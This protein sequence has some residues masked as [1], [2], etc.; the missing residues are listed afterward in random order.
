MSIKCNGMKKV[1]RMIDEHG[2]KIEK[3]EDDTMTETITWHKT[4]NVLPE[5]SPAFLQCLIELLIDNGDISAAYYDPIKNI[6]M[7]YEY[8]EIEAPVYWAYAPSGPTQL[9]WEAE[10]KTKQEERHG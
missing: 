3:L 6:F 10:Q 8:E 2:N 9:K 4:S 1:K 7:D 5:S